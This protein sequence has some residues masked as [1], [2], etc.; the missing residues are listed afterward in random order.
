MKLEISFARLDALR[1]R[2]GASLRPWKAEIGLDQLKS[3]TYVPHERDIANLGE[4][5]VGDGDTI[6]HDGHRVFLYIR[7]FH[8]KADSFDEACADPDK[9]RK[10]HIVWC[11]TLQEMKA[12]GRFE[13]YIASDRVDEPFGVAMRTRA[14]SWVCGDTE[15]YVCRFCLNHTDWGGYRDATRN[16][17]TELVRQF[18]RRRFLETDHTRFA[19]LPAQNDSSSPAMGYAADW[20]Q[21][22]RDYRASMGFRC[23]DCGVDCSTHRGL[24][25]SHHQNGVTTDNRRQNLR[26]LC[27]TCH[28]Q[29]HPNWYIVTP[30]DSQTLDALRAEQR[31]QAIMEQIK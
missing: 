30:A 21:R 18:S 26:A 13:R 28:A 3:I 23:E 12:A 17:R 9:L 15:L 5:Q 11:Q 1:Q 24:L 14:G 8:V 25:D 27:K 10:F 2:M 22:S 16:C 29:R 4:L 6:L 20:T 31:R 7:E 19:E